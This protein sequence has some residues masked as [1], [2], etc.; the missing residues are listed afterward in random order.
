MAESVCSEDH[1]QKQHH[2]AEEGLDSCTGF[3]VIGGGIAGVTCAE[4]LAALC[5]DGDQITLISASPLIK[6]VT[7]F[8]Q[9]NSKTHILSVTTLHCDYM[10]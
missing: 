1:T 4:T 7:N 5:P 10:V 9:V 6:T 8:N 3:V 2:V